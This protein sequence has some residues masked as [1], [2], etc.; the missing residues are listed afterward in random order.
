M[1]NQQNRSYLYGVVGGYL[2]FLAY[3]L[4]A[5]RQDPNTTMAPAVRW[6]FVGLFIAAGI[7]LL[8]W[9]P[10]L[11]LEARKG[12]DQEERPPENPN[13]MK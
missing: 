2:L 5:D 12:Q 13:A 3:E 7:I 9:A 4:F 10:R 1:N 11:R 8:I 6:L